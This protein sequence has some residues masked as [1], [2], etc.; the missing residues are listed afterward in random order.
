MQFAPDERR[1]KRLERPLGLT[2]V[3]VRPPILVAGLTTNRR[4]DR[5]FIAPGKPSPERGLLHDGSVA[6]TRGSKPYG[7]LRTLPSRYGEGVRFWLSCLSAASAI[8]T[9]P[10]SQRC[11]IGVGVSVV[12]GI[13]SELSKA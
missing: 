1:S 4:R 5:P 3:N 2:V 7:L 8:C 10:L 13:P 6:G 9:Q 11:G 12:C